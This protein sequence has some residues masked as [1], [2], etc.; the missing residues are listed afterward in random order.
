[1]VQAEVED[2]EGEQDGQEP[3]P[4]LAPEGVPVEVAG[5]VFL[6]QVAG[7]EEDDFVERDQG[8]DADEPGEHEAFEFGFDKGPAGFFL[9]GEVGEIARDKKYCGHDENIEDK[10][11]DAGQIVG[12]RIADD[13]PGGA[14]AVFF[15]N[16]GRVDED[17]QEDHKGTQI[18]EPIDSVGLVVRLSGFWNQHCESPYVRVS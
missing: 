17:D 16:D 10:K 2:F 6:R 1:M 15:V 11:E 12:G 14:H 5:P 9:E 18:V 7:V 13:P 3:E 8:E 4:V